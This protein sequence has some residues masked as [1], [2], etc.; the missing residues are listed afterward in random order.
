MDQDTSQRL[1]QRLPQYAHLRWIETTGSTNDDLLRDADSPHLSVLLAEHQTG[2][3]GRLGRTWTAPPGTQLIVSILFRPALD[4]LDRLGTLPLVAG[5]ALSD[6]LDPAT[7]KWPNDVLIDGRKL[8]GILLE[9]AGLPDDPRVVIGIGVNVSLTREQLPVAH[10]TSLTLESIDVGREDFAVAVLTALHRRLEQ[11][12]EHD[13]KL[14]ESY[15]LVCSSIGQQVRVETPRGTLLGSVTG[16]GTDGLL[17]LID[18]R[19]DNHRLSA[20]D[21]THLRRTDS[22]Y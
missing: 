17:E 3:H 10:A 21:V 16:V 8:S 6:V 14:M 22:D 9:A 1:R 19:G 18:D 20:G 7:L 5:L 2:G 13:P 11:W 12:L 15:R 4:E